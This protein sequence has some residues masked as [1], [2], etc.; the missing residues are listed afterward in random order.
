MSFKNSNQ[1]YITITLDVKER[2]SLIEKNAM[3]PTTYTLYNLH[4]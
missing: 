3:Q 4:V 2:N 1:Y